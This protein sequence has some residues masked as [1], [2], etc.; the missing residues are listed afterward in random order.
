MAWLRNVSIRDF[1]FHPDIGEFAREEIAYAARQLADGP[2]LA[3]R[4]QVEL[5]LASVAGIHRRSQFTSQKIRVSA[6]L[7]T[8][9]VTIGK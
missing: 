5:E 2:H 3:L 4:N 8:R 9:H 6:A 7:K 1:T